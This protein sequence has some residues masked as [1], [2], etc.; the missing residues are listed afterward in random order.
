[1]HGISP[2]DSLTSLSVSNVGKLGQTLGSLVQRKSGVCP[3]FV[4]TASCFKEFVILSGI[5][6][7]VFSLLRSKKAQQ[8]H[9]LLL[10]QEVPDELE[11]DIFNHCASLRASHFA[12]QSSTAFPNHH[13]WHHAAGKH[14]VLDAIKHCWASPV[15]PERVQSLTKAN[16]FS[17]VVVQPDP[18]GAKK[19]AMYTVNPFTNSTEKMVIEL[20]EPSYH[21]L[22]VNKG[23]KRVVN[24]DDFFTL[25]S[26]LYIDEKDALA[27]L[28]GQVNAL[29]RKAQA[30]DWVKLGSGFAITRVHDLDTPEKQALFDR[31]KKNGFDLAKHNSKD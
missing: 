15:T 10:N 19:G 22:L 11:E 3:S 30:I 8:L 13:Y 21:V 9:D 14:K 25:K 7:R 28:A 24:E 17:A 16:L 31:V 6:D 18:P 2:L 20:Y 5:R 26:P 29:Y 23:N 1:M 12:C 27:A 4:V